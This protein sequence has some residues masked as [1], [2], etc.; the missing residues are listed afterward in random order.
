[1]QKRVTQRDIAQKAGVD[2]STVSLALN[3]HPRIPATTRARILDIAQE[4]GYRPDPALSSIAASRW[5]GHR[6]ARGMVLAFLVDDLRKAEVELKLYLEGVRQQADSLGYL[7]E[8][9]S[10]N[11]YPHAQAVL[12]VIRA[13][14]MR[15]IIIGQSRE[16]VPDALDTQAPVPVVHCGY[17]REVS[18]DIVRPDLRKAVGELLQRLLQRFTR[19]TCFLP[20]EKKLHA[21]REILGAALAV[22]RIERRGRIRV[23]QPPPGTCS[24]NQQLIDA[25]PEAIVTI[26]EK[27]ATRLRA[28]FPALNA[29]PIYTIHTLP[30][31]DGKQGMDLRLRDVGRASVNLLE[32]KLRHLPLATEP[33]RQNLQIAPQ[34]LG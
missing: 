28:H 25:R 11:Q 34:W 26:N 9:I 8:P 1:M 31:F 3:K 14:G 27:H 32:M 13:R 2:V 10:L 5:A 29:I 4:L 16:D 21:D 20:V 23:L 22:S 15:G 19:I 12:R 30:P 24:A 6:D 7:L 17:L 18:G 33:F